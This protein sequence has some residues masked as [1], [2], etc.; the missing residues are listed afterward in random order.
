LKNSESIKLF[1]SLHNLVQHVHDE[2]IMDKICTILTLAKAH[3][4]FIENLIDF[5]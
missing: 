5:S 2:A 4:Y 3:Y 1:L